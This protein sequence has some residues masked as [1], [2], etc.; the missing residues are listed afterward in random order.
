MLWLAGLTGL[1]VLANVFAPVIFAGH[2]LVLG[3]VFYWVALR[4]VG[5]APALIVLAAGTASLW[6]KWGQPYS[7]LL[8]AL[9][10]LAVGAVW[11]RQRSPLLAD[12]GFWLVLGTPVSWFLYRHVYTIPQPSFGQAL[13]V[14]PL[15]GLLSV[16]LAYL[17][18]EQIPATGTWHGRAD[19]SFRRVLLSRYVAFGTLPVVAAT[20]I[21]VRSLELR[22]IDE[23]NTSLRA[24]ALNLAGTIDRQ[25]AEASTTIREF[26]ARQR[27][28]GW[29]ADDAG[30]ARALDTLHARSGLFITMLA[31]GSDG[32]ILASAPSG[33][34]RERAGA[35]PAPPVIDREYFQAPM[36]TG[37]AQVS[38]V[39]RGRGFGRDLLVAVSA[40][41][42][43]DQGR[44]AGVIEGSLLVASLEEILRRYTDGSR[45]RAILTDRKLRVITDHGFSEEPL[46]TINDPRLR[47]LIAAARPQPSRVTGERG[48]ERVSFLST[49]VPLPHLG[50]TLTLQREWSDVLRPVT[51]AYAWSLLIAVTTVLF[52][53]FF[54]TWSLRDFLRA[55]RDTIAF[56]RAPTV[57]SSLLRDSARLDL[58][59]EFSELIGNLSRM[60]ER[61]EAE[62]HA[63]EE[64]LSRLEERVR[65]R[66]AELEAAVA[67]A[68]S[69]DR[70]KGVF[71][72]TVTHELRT[73]LT[74][75]IT[76]VKLLR[77]NP[78]PRP[79]AETR[80]LATLDNASRSLMTVI[81]DVLDYSKLEAGAVR[82]EV[83]PF[84]PAEVVAEAASILDPEVQR[85]RLV[86]RTFAE[87]PAD[88]VWR[89]DGLR[90]RQVLLNLAGNA[91][92]FTP[93]G[94]VDILTWTTEEPRRLWFAVTDTGPG[95]PA[96]R[97]ETIFEAFVQLESNQVQS[98]AGT[99]LGLSISRR[100]VELMGGKIRAAD[101]GGRGARFEFW[102]PEVPPTRPPSNTPFPPPA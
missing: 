89:S 99:G 50:W 90:V 40:P 86:L 76:G 64:L 31:A 55:W 43:N 26:A 15:N 27:E 94:R 85:A 58:P 53:T 95:I 38:G 30:L 8:L 100:L 10:G 11:R 21:A 61:L 41:V 33:L 77:M 36:E 88:L 69:A 9:E 56:S 52:A 6:L 73:P 12:L 87:H 83:S 63:R 16:W 80:T 51:A 66:T 74:A 34:Q 42:I 65:A 60:A 47:G 97:L 49:S 98:Q 44:P 13:V 3:G 67:R 14:Q 45:T 22:T 101:I 28:P 81:S 4:A 102:L 78:A 84:R 71:L 5:P 25:V 75:I 48:G 59:L 72:S 68:Q 7:A 54:T 24:A 32:R 91:V 23:A 20:L 82:I 19:R 18:L 79:E 92:K 1:A 39:F 35:E 37:R 62:R 2:S 57:Q 46:N 93:A 70:A 29:G 17:V 96:E